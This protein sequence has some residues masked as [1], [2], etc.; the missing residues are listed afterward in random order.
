MQ[1]RETDLLALQ[2]ALRSGIE[3]LFPERV[4][5]RAEISA[6][7]VKAGGHCYL[8]LSQSE[9]GRLV[10]KARAIIWKSQYRLIDGTFRAATGFP[11]SEGMKVLVE[12]QVS[13]SELY[14]LSLIVSDIDPA[15]TVGD[16]EAERQRTLE[17]LEREGLLRLQEKCFLPPLPYRLAVISAETAAGYQDFLRQLHENEY[18]F[19]LETTLF[20]ALMQGRDCPA[21]LIS[22]MNQ[23]VAEGR[24]DAILILRGGGSKL[25]LDCF[26]DYDLAAAIARCPVPV[27]TAVGHDRDVHVCDKVA[28]VSVRTPTA[29]ADEFLEYYVAEDA[30][31]A[32]FGTR[33][34]MAFLG[35]IAA[36]SA[37]I[38]LLEA[39]IKGAD[40]RLVLKRGY[41][42]A[43]D[44][45]E[46]V[47]KSVAGLEAG[48]RMKFMFADGTLR[49]R[50]EAVERKAG[51]GT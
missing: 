22:A 5:V 14:G 24:Y 23:A 39:R 6:I 7:S 1:R 33:L 45:R 31:I 21:S 43:L 42:L 50:I 19:V 11:L 25:D 35:R 15:Y 8:E 18:G 26:D 16:R 27:F 32:S 36:M 40:P 30:R 46:V 38:D 9:E 41:I 28:Y 10:A 37:K 20:P 47:V 34:R 48:D 49:C 13:Y 12:A 3:E 17:R 51:A 2:R 29:L 44:S 4:W